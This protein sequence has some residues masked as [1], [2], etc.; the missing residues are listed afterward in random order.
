MNYDASAPFRCGPTTSTA[1][2][3]GTTIFKL[4]QTGSAENPFLRQGSKHRMFFSLA[5][6]KKLFG[7][8][9]L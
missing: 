3:G 2:L 4:P 8:G 1:R 5:D 6:K 7:S 9:M